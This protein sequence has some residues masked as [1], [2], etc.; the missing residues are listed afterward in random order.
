M[1][2][3]VLIRVQNDGFT[4]HML[5][6]GQEASSISRAERK[7]ILWHLPKRGSGTAAYSI[8]KRG[9]TVIDE[10]EVRAFCDKARNS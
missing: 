1:Q 2:C 10:R 5:H 7:C 4:E 6:N 8:D 3:A 9:S